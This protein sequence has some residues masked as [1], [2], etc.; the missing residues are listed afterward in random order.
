MNFKALGL[1]AAIAFAA[2]LSAHAVTELAPGGIYDIL[3]DDEFRFEL[4]GTPLG[5]QDLDFTFVLNPPAERQPVAAIQ[6]TIIG[7]TVD[8]PQMNF[9]ATDLDYVQG[10]GFTGATISEADFTFFGSSFVA[11]LTTILSASTGGLTQV[12]NIGFGAGTGNG[13]ISLNVQPVP[14]PASVLLF[15]TALAGLGFVSRRKA[16]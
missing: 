10:I 15:M 6:L 9:A 12:L 14:L 13:Q 3:S 2:P 8:L 11:T 5:F 1:A 4:T 7:S 16:A